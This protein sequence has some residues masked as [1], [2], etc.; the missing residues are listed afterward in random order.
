[1]STPTS[2]LRSARGFMLM[3]VL[4][5][6]L[7][8]SLGVLGLVKL[9]ASMTRASTSAKARADANY[10]VSEILGV[11]RT[12]T[13][14]L[15]SYDSGSCASYPLCKDWTN[16]VAASL[17]NANPTITAST[18]PT[19]TVTLTWTLPSED[20]HTFTTTTILKAAN[21]P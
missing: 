14:H 3:E 19:V 1:M 5:S 15:S 12:D 18:A 17:P 9:Q 21:A 2:P 10:L 7:V 20:T 8:F 16:K 13:A 4:I 6:I 11:M